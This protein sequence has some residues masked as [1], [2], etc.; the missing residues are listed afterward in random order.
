MHNM[1]F[2]IENSQFK[3][4][5]VMQEIIITLA[6]PFFASLLSPTKSHLTIIFLDQKIYQNFELNTPIELYNE[7]IKEF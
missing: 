6:T 2:I 7:I 3:K 4:I 1:K 5:S